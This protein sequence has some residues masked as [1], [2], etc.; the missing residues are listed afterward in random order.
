MGGYWKILQDKLGA[1]P[2]GAPEP[3]SPT[4]D[5]ERFVEMVAAIQEQTE[6]QPR[7]ELPDES[8]KSLAPKRH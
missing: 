4:A 7:Q 1:L 2:G 8:Y 5:W 3:K 6:R